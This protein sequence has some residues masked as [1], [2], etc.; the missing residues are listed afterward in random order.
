MPALAHSYRAPVDECQHPLRVVMKGT[1]GAIP[2]DAVV[3][4]QS[5]RQHQARG[6]NSLPFHFGLHLG[7]GD[8]QDRHFRAR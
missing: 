5:Q 3:V 7:L 8:A 6:T 2:D 4:A 1:V